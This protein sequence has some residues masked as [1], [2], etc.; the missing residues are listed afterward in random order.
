[1]ENI[2]GIRERTIGR[3]SAH[4]PVLRHLLGQELFGPVPVQH[5]QGGQGAHAQFEHAARGVRAARQLHSDLPAASLREAPHRPQVTAAS[6]SA[7]DS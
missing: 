3:P 7:V 4:D 6:R 1:M 2:G 5:G